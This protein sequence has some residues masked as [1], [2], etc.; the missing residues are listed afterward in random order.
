MSHTKRKWYYTNK[1]F[2][3]SLKM[4]ANLSRSTWWAWKMQRARWQV[5][6]YSYIARRGLS[7]FFFI[8]FETYR[9]S[10]T[11]QVT[12]IWG[13]TR[14]L[15]GWAWPHKISLSVAC[16]TLFSI[17]LDFTERINFLMLC[18]KVITLR[19]ISIY[20]NMKKYAMVVHVTF[21]LFSLWKSLMAKAIKWLSS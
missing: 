6:I 9:F 21:L 2:L 11:D 4:Y 7:L 13:L 17:V 14:R 16:W 10:E 8:H 12:L 19:I 20:K 18:I 5:C 3:N 1:V 15:S